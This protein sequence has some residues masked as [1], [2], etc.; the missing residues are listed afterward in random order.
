[1]IQ[2]MNRLI[3]NLLTSFRTCLDHYAHRLSS[4]DKQGSKYKEVFEKAQSYCFD[5]SFAYRF[6][7]KLRNYVQH[8]GLPV[9]ELF[10]SLEPG[11]EGR[12]IHDIVLFI[13]RDDLIRKYD[14]WGPVK[15]EI[16]L[17]PEKIDIISL[18]RN[19]T[20]DIQGLSALCARL[21][22]G[23]LAGH[24]EYLLELH[25]EIQL[26]APKSIPCV[27][28]I[29]TSPGDKS[30]DIKISSIPL[31][32]MVKMQGLARIIEFISICDIL[33]FH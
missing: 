1:M 30:V 28:S 26:K 16:K 13:N 6:F 33:L 2:E 32:T 27:A 21:E 9:S 11:P 4:I 23:R 25:N 5:N 10:G 29:T 20:R 18:V 24:W 14:G 3:M 15:K 8:S 22:L 12:V 31:Y 17:Q 7:C 19:F